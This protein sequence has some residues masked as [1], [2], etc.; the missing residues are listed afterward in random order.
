MR[1]LVEAESTRVPESL[2][3]Q[4]TRC[5]G[6]VLVSVEGRQQL[7]E[8][9]EADAP[10]G[11]SGALAALIALSS[12]SVPTV[13]DSALR[14]IVHSCAHPSSAAALFMRLPGGVARIHELLCAPADDKRQLTALSAFFQL[15]VACARTPLAAVPRVALAELGDAA[16]PP[17]EDRQP[18]EGQPEDRQPGEGQHLVG[19]GGGPG[20]GLSEPGRGRQRAVRGRRVVQRHGAYAGGPKAPTAH[21]WRLGNLHPCHPRF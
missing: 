14:A 15:A 12:H 7:T 6:T 1:C 4:A 3:H 9:S 2:L 11:P 16:P 5:L 18:E 17:P 8:L 20:G 19:D 13:G 21:H 10:G